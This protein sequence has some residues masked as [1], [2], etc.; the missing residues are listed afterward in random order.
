ML[1]VAD[2]NIPLVQSAFEEFGEIRVLDRFSITN[3]AVRDAEALL[4][5]SETR[6]NEELLAGSRV[7]FVASATAGIDHIDA[8][9]LQDA[10]IAFSDAAGCNANSV[11]E[12]IVA[13]LL[14]LST[15]HH[16]QLQG[17][18]IGII[19]VGHVGSI[20]AKYA[21]SLGLEVLLNDPPRERETGR[22]DFLPLEGLM[23]ADIITLHVPLTRTGPDR[24][25]HL[26][27]ANR[28]EKLKSTCVFINAS[29]GGVVET[30]A[31]KNAIRSRKP[32]FTVLDVW[33]NEP[34]IDLE[35]LRLVDIGSAHIA[36]YS[37][38]G[39]IN[40]THLIRNAFCRHFGFSSGWDPS[41]EMH[42]P[43]VS[44]ID[45]RAADSF[46]RTLND[47]VKKCYDITVDD[48]NMRSL[49]AVP[50][51]EADKRFIRLRRDY[52]VRRE[53]FNTSVT[54]TSLAPDTARVLTALGFKSV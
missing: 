17:K 35:L 30:S 53:F 44:H 24:T 3:A 11:A 48:A 33:E 28:I 50:E 37:L 41:A 29:R 46:E 14:H 2:V 19:G 8:A 6:V 34:G 26:F 54:T 15:R 31:I 13:A 38:D 36:G 25:L 12:Y 49:F 40:G 10:G 5:R 18:S 32:A 4:V 52:R 21:K 23:D 9:Y 20:V 39:K 51:A 47:V 1:I 45:V 7:R 27:D 43:A 42:P 22:T 16:F